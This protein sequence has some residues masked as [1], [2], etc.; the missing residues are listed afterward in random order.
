MTAMETHTQKNKNVK[1]WAA[2]SNWPGK[3]KPP[4]QVPRFLFLTDNLK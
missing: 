4:W 2:V 3:R 1:V